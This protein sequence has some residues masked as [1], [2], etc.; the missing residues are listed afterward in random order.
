MRLKG[1]I[2]ANFKNTIFPLP[3]L[4]ARTSNRAPRSRC[5]SRPPW[6]WARGATSLGLRRE[7][8]WQGFDVIFNFVTKRKWYFLTENYWPKGQGKQEEGRPWHLACVADF[9]SRDSPR[10]YESPSECLF[11]RFQAVKSYKR[12]VFSIREF[13]R[14]L[15][16]PKLSSFVMVVR[17]K[18]NFNTIYHLPCRILDL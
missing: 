6:T 15:Y 2:C 3:Y 18:I 7:L 8:G 13:Y 14:P 10:K 5:I 12:S 16:P 17:F 9:T 11:W 1:Q 4:R